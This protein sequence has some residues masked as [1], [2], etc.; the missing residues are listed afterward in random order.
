MFQDLYSAPG[1]GAVQQKPSHFKT[2][3]KRIKQQQSSPFLVSFPPG[4]GEPSCPGAS[5]AWRDGALARPGHKLPVA[6]WEWSGTL[7]VRASPPSRTDSPP[8]VDNNT[9]D[10][11]K[12]NNKSSCLDDV[13]PFS[14]LLSFTKCNPVDSKAPLGTQDGRRRHST[15]K[16]GTPNNSWQRTSGREEVDAKTSRGTTASLSTERS[17]AGPALAS[18]QSKQLQRS[19]TRGGGHSKSCLCSA[20]LYCISA[21]RPGCTRPLQVQAPVGGLP[22]GPTRPSPATA[23][24]DASAPGVPR[25]PEAHREAE[26]V[27]GPEDREDLDNTEAHVLEYEQQG[28]LSLLCCGQITKT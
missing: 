4:Q 7:R 5:A 18:S 3:A 8:T 22:S 10:T 9:Y 6:F 2:T 23:A 11:H 27:Q 26:H 17:W 14:L 21:D 28:S 1:T 12:R 24:R 25:S 15:A 16:G 13:K 19:A 20:T